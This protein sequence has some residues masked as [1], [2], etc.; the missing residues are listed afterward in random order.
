MLR[1]VR[2]RDTHVMGM[3]DARPLLALLNRK[4]GLWNFTLCIYNKHRPFSCGTADL[5][6]AACSPLA[7][8]PR[9]S[10]RGQRPRVQHMGGIN[11]RS[12]SSL[13]LEIGPRLRRPLSK[14]PLAYALKTQIQPRPAEFPLSVVHFMSPCSGTPTGFTGVSPGPAPALVCH[15]ALLTRQAWLS[16]GELGRFHQLSG[17]PITQPSPQ[18]YQ[19][20]AAV[21]CP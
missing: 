8:P 20:A 7:S 3:V 10:F 1:A 4:S 19:S 11:A 13:P 15:Y 21:S 6:A 12:A 17:S 2:Q 5:A 18:P 9:D 16:A 14:I